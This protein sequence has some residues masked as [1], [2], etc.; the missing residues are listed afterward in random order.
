MI[1]NIT[2]RLRQSAIA[3]GCA[4]A[5][6]PVYNNLAMEDITV[7]D[8]YRGNLDKLSLIRQKWDSAKIMDRTGGFRIP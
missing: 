2:S 3:L 7:A 1:E 5:G 4:V 6:A 8:I